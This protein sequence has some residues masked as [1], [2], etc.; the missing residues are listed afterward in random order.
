MRCEHQTRYSSLQLAKF[1][2]RIGQ[3][4]ST[5]QPHHPALLS[6]RNAEPAYPF[7]VQREKGSL[8]LSLTPGRPTTAC[9]V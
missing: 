1:L 8:H 4:A 2:L 9:K 5:E 7:R 6:C 3:A